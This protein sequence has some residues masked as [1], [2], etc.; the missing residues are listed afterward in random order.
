VIVLILKFLGWCCLLVPLSLVSTSAP[1]ISPYFGFLATGEGDAAGEGL[2]A[3]LGL[4]AGAVTVLLGENAGDGDDV[5]FGEFELFPGSQ[6]AAKAIAR[7]VGSNIVVRRI[8]FSFGLLIV[9]PRSS[10][11]EKRGDDC[12]D[13]NSQQWV[14]PQVS[15]RN[16]RSKC[17]ETLVFERVLARLTNAV[18]VVFRTNRNREAHSLHKKS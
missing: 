17:T 9:L 4:V 1:S 18:C 2:A 11:I 16:L 6:P 15:R 13:A 7:I 8:N 10:K 14:F 3:G 5:T 12:P